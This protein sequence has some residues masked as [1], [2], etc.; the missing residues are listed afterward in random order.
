MFEPGSRPVFKFSNLTGPQLASLAKFSRSVLKAASISND[1]RP[2]CVVASRRAESFRRA[3]RQAGLLRVTRI[4]QLFLGIES[5][6]RQER[7]STRKTQW[8]DT[9][10]TQSVFG[11]AARHGY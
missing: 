11:S 9:L 2:T 4:S 7:E 6:S 3:G 10:T 5:V 1:C 8:L